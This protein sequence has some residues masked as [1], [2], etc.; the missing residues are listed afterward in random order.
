MRIRKSDPPSTRWKRLVEAPEAVLVARIRA[1][2]ANWWHSAGDIVELVVNAQNDMP[3][4]ALAGTLERMTGENETFLLRFAASISMLQLR[5]DAPEIGETA[6]RL[7]GSWPS[8]PQEYE[9]VL[10]SFQKQ[11]WRRETGY[12][13]L[14]YAVPGPQRPAQDPAQFSTEWTTTE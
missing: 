14:V 11:S 12:F 2:A 13:M 8:T 10:E 4:E 7:M 3:L 9:Q 5:G 6:G 1:H